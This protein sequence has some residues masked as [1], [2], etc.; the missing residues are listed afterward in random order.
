MK[1]R[2]LAALILLG[3]VNTAGAVRVLKE[4]ERPFEISVGQLTLPADAG[5]TL[6][7]RE[8]D[9]C[10]F[11]SYRLQGSTQF[12]LD[13]RQANYADFRRTVDGLRASAAGNATVISVFIDRTTERVTRISVRQPR[14]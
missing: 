4:V 1:T 7:L 10:K 14:R 6:T 12:V 13:G 2:I 5:G 3:L 11:G 9:T 8:C